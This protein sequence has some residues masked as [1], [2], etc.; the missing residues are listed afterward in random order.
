MQSVEEGV[1]EL[2]LWLSFIDSRRIR[3]VV[4]PPMGF[5][6]KFHGLKWDLILKTM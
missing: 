3:I 6:N 4:S 2:I 1:T 5:M